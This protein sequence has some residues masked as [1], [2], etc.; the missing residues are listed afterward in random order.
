MH[1]PCSDLHRRISHAP[2]PHN[3]CKS[4]ASTRNENSPA[5]MAARS[6]RMPRLTSP[7][8][9]GEAHTLQSH[10]QVQKNKDG[11]HK[12]VHE[13]N[14]TEGRRERR[15]RAMVSMDGKHRPRVNNTQRGTGRQADAHTRL[16]PCAWPWLSASAAVLQ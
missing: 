16:E 2:L 11:A 7:E 14:A 4:A 5:K 13:V 6:P 3:R 9:A 1:L 15:V 8:T 10:P 12:A